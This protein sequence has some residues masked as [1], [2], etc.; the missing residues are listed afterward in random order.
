[1]CFCFALYCG[2]GWKGVCLLSAHWHMQ[3]WYILQVPSSWTSWDWNNVSFTFSSLFKWRT[4]VSHTH[5]IVVDGKAGLL[6]CLRVS[7]SLS[8][9]ACVCFFSPKHSNDWLEFIS[10]KCFPNHHGHMHFLNGSNLRV[11]DMFPFARLGWTYWNIMLCSDDAFLN[12]SNLAVSD[13]FLFA[14]P[15]WTYIEASF[16]A[17]MHSL[18]ESSLSVIEAFPF[19][20]SGWTYIETCFIFNGCLWM[21]QGEPFHMHFYLDSWLE[22]YRN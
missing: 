5:T 6:G 19:G 4:C 12:G 15:S 11:S 13:A 21:C 22:I 18:K 17:H 16:C 8:I 20:H 14:P 2:P 9:H 7:R 3:V 10:S 1:M